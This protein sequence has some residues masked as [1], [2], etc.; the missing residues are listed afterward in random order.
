M[1]TP[2]PSYYDKEMVGVFQGQKGSPHP[3]ETAF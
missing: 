2:S 1:L 3:D